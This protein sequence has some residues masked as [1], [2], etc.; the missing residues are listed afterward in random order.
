MT[1]PYKP[2]FVKGKKGNCLL[3]GQDLI[4]KING[5]PAY[6]SGRL[7]KITPSGTRVIQIE[8]TGTR[9]NP[10]KDRIKFEMKTRRGLPMKPGKY[11]VKTVA[12]F[13]GRGEN[14]WTDGFDVV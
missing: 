8:Q 11:L 13:T 12:N 7:S 9:Q 5:K 3:V 10:E 2:N 1:S 4:I 14:S 6:I